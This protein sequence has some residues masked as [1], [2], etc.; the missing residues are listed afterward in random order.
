MSFNKVR[1][2]IQEV[3]MDYVKKL[4]EGEGHLNFMKERSAQISKGEV[5]PF[6]FTSLC[7]FPTY[8]ADFGWGKP[9]W[10]GSSP[11]PYRNLVVFL[12]TRDGGGIEA[13][14]NLKPEDMALFEKDK[15]LLSLVSSSASLNAK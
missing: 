2:A 1:E 11:L 14:A 15:E 9:M 12:D 7:R 3:N 13:Y 6:S 8:E 4:R 5:V 10:V